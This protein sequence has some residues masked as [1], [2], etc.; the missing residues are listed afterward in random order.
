MPTLPFYT[1]RPTSAVPGSVGAGSNLV[2]SAMQP[3]E[4][5]R[6]LK[7]GALNM[8]ETRRALQE[9]EALQQVNARASSLQ[10]RLK[11]VEL[12]AAET[13]GNA[14]DYLAQVKAETDQVWA[15]A[16]D[17]LSASQTRLLAP[18][19]D[20]FKSAQD[21]AITQRE[22]FKRRDSGRAAIVDHEA[23][24]L[25]IFRNPDSSP[26]DRSI[27][28]A[29]Y[30]EALD[31]G[32]ASGFFTHEDAATVKSAFAAKASEM[33]LKAGEDAFVSHYVG[34]IM[35]NYGD[36]PTLAL[37]MMDQVE[38]PDSYVQAAR[39]ELE[40]RLTQRNKYA[41]QDEEDFA[42]QLA[43]SMAADPFS[44]TLRDIKDNPRVA[45]R[46]KDDLVRLKI[47]L[48]KNG[49]GGVDDPVVLNKIFSAMDKMTD[50]EFGSTNFL[51][52]LVDDKG[53]P[54]LTSAT[55]RRVASL[56]TQARGTA[57]GRTSADSAASALAAK[58]LEEFRKQLK[59]SLST[60]RQMGKDRGLSGDEL[61]RFVG[62]FTNALLAEDEPAMTPARSIIIADQ[63]QA[64]LEMDRGGA[65]DLNPFDLEGPYYN[66]TKEQKLDALREVDPGEWPDTWNTII[67]YEYVQQKRDE[68]ASK[69]LSFTA[70][71]RKAAIDEL[72]RIKKTDEKRFRQLSEKLLAN[73]LEISGD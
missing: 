9:A 2:T 54:T 36:N 32:A 71:D 43:A 3:S 15:E 18:K 16:Y 51:P 41:R 29:N 10:N 24:A 60:A 44:V 45:G 17:G 22:L 27:A 21:F 58:Q 46:L 35:Q 59:S 53:M 61:V 62:S 68:A 47:S 19:V 8:L 7:Q 63:V 55:M 42:G 72:D 31:E 20:V 73:E 5:D 34:Q 69:G 65:I 26:I 56:Q 37:K 64:D 67:N 13:T 30:F 52:D 49:A 6:A 14:D 50:A 25:A 4:G 48:T 28:Q 70:D 40:D 1:G 23:G 39:D 66:W 33:N 12:R 11:E 57:S 38:G